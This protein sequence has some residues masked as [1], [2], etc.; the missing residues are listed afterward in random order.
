MGPIDLLFHVLSFIAPALALAILLP[1]GGRV[2]LPRGQ[3]LL[4]W[5][6]QVAFNAIVGI[7]ILALGL[8]HFGVDGKMATYAALVLGM[9][10]AQWLGSAGWRKS[11]S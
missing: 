7:G 2:L 1:L 10:M 4:S 5:W 11:R 6:V 9:A 3:V 8:W